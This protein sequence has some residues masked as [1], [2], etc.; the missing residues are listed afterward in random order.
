MQSFI[1]L[2]TEWDDEAPWIYDETEETYGSCVFRTKY[3]H[4]PS[5]IIKLIE[6]QK[7]RFFDIVFF[8]KKNYLDQAICR[9]LY[10]VL[11]DKLLAL[12]GQVGTDDEEMLL[13]ALKRK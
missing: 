9:L 6:D 10:E 7:I 5:S 2:Q 3:P 11:V 4:N 13:K 8:M 12:A 1:S